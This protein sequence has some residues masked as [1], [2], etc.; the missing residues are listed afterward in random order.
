MSLDGLTLGFIARELSESLLGGRVDKIQQPEKDMVVLTI[1]SGGQNHRLLINANPTGT[2]IHLTQKSYESPLQAP[3]FTMLMRKHLMS[4]R[5][6]GI[7]QMFGDRLIRIDIASSDEMG[8]RRDKQLYFEAMGRHTNLSLVQ[9]GTI[10]DCLRHVTDDMSR[11]RQMLPGLPYELPPAQE[12]IAPEDAQAE[13]FV[14]QFGEIGGRADKALAGSVSGLG[15][16]SAAEICLRITGQEQPHLK[17]LN[18][19]TFSTK[20]A[21]FLQNLDD[22]YAPQLYTDEEGLPREALPFP[23]FSLERARQQAMPS[24]SEALDQLYYERDR[25]QRLMQRSQAFRRSLKTAEERTLKKLAIQEEELQASKRMD[26][27]RMAGEMLTSFGHLVPKGARSAELPNYYNDSI[28][29]VELDPSMSPAQNAQKYF[30]RYRRAVTAQRL[31]AEQ[32][33]HT[34]TELV[35][36]EDALYAVEQAH[37]MQDIAEIKV[38]LSLAGI[39]K[40]EAKPKQKRQEKHSEPLHFIS[41]DG[42][43]ILVGK[44]SLQN[45][46][47]LKMAQGS[48]IW[49]HAKDMPGSHVIL[50]CEGKEASDEALLMA[51][52]LASYY[53]KGKGHQVG[54]NYTFRK[55]V[56]KPGGSPAGFVNFTEEKLIVMSVSE[57]E[58]RGMKN[59]A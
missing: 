59:P 54:V 33:E 47:L 6:M 7:V 46:R 15:A 50:R 13:L 44:N 22:L 52:K 53:S 20:L 11:V 18:I 42:F 45:E 37:T 41:D 26:E 51:A 28:L 34:L 4:G 32:K 57:Q 56:K 14:Q 9:D 21:G 10:L 39:I 40:A 3:V 30:K 8:E 48:D 16:A 58:I 12:K 5:V 35:L 31:A 17:D 29:S 49:L 25:H 19:E 23:F 1:R 36:I 43:N 27:Y 38:P 24:L 55:H 2:R